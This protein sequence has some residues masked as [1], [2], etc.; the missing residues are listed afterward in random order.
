MSTGI[1]GGT[2][3]QHGTLRVAARMALAAVP[4]F[5]W[6]ISVAALAGSLSEALIVFLFVLALLAALVLFLLGIVLG[7]SGSAA[8]DA[9]AGST[10]ISLT[11]WFV[12]GF[13]ADLL[14]GMLAASYLSQVATSLG[15]SQ[16][17][18]FWA[19]INTRDALQFVAFSL[20][21]GIAGGVAASIYLRR[22]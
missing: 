11:T 8:I 16:V 21:G 2:V 22:S 3:V 6:K 14:L 20:G 9:A 7:K 12:A 10:A 15:D 13:I 17:G 5:V 4:Y 19:D 18:S 1:T